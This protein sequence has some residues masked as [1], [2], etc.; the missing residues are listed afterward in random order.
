[1]TSEFGLVCSTLSEYHN[2]RWQWGKC[3]ASGWAA[4]CKHHL[5]TR[6][7]YWRGGKA[8]E[9][10]SAKSVHSSH[11]PTAISLKDG[12]AMITSCHEFVNDLSTIIC[13]RM[14]ISCMYS[15]HWLSNG[16][17][18]SS[19]LHPERFWGLT[20]WPEREAEFTISSPA[21]AER[22]LDFLCSP[23]RSVA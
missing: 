14:F 15:C 12:N 23:S 3:E 19:P 13:F 1:M 6:R 22:Y 18:F 21:E 20:K 9:G 17:I 7:A 8:D 10:S 5:G 2:I 4:L 16:T 11:E